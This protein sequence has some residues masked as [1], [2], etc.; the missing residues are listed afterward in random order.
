MDL[1]IAA[2]RTREVFEDTPLP[3]KGL[4]YALSLVAT[5]V[6]FW[7][8]WRRVAKYRRGRSTG[9]RAS[10]RQVARPWTRPVHTS[11][12][13]VAA[14]STV[15]RRNRATGLAQL[16]VFWGFIT[17]FIG[18]VILT[19]NEDIVGVGSQVATGKKERFFQ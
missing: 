8:S 11:V 2:E 19:I 12:G 7:G 15:A 13:A 3:A 4:F 16:A 17:L 14:N 10:G 18:T 6:F 5:A 9:R 1:L